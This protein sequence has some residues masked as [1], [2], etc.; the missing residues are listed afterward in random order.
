[1]LSILCSRLGCSRTT[2]VLKSF[3]T[4][5][6]PFAGSWFHLV[7]FPLFVTFN[8]LHFNSSLLKGSLLLITHSVVLGPPGVQLTKKHAMQKSAMLNIRLGLM[9]SNS[10]F[11]LLILIHTSTSTSKQRSINTFKICYRLQRKLSSFQMPTLQ[12]R[13]T[14]HVDTLPVTLTLH[15]SLMKRVILSSTWTTPLLSA[16]QQL[17][18]PIRLD[19]KDKLN[20]MRD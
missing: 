20:L 10:S 13:S 11:S 9:Q 4:S 15:N 7:L 12:R 2:T 18:Q 19:Q 1:M 17:Q 8:A 14:L 5:V 16:L 6:S 3:R